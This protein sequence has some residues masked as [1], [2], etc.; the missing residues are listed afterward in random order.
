MPPKKRQPSEK[1]TTVNRIRRKLANTKAQQN[2]NQTVS[3]NA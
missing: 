3:R 2:K 1:N